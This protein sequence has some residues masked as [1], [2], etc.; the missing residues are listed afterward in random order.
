MYT[1]KSTLGLLDQVGATWKNYATNTTPLSE[2]YRTFSS[3]YLTVHDSYIDK[4]VFV[5]MGVYKLMLTSS[6]QTVDE[7][8]NES[9]NI[10]LATVDALPTAGL[11]S[12]FYEN[13]VLRGYKMQLTKI[14]MTIPENYPT[15]ALDDLQIS[16]PGLPTDMR[17]LHTHCLLSV[18]GYYHTSDADDDYAYII[19]GGVTATSKRCAHT[20]IL[21]FMDIGS[22]TMHRFKDE[23]LVPLTENTPLKDGM[24]IRTDQDLT[25]KSVFMVLGGYIVRPS[26]EEFWQNGDKSFVFY[27][28][29]IPYV[30]RY[31]ESRKDID[32]SSMPVIVEDNDGDQGRLGDNV[33]QESLWS[34]ECLRAYFKISQSFLVIVDTDTLFFSNIPIRVSNIS[35][36]LTS[37]T[38]PQFPLVMGYGKSVE[39]SKVKETSWWALRVTDA[40]YKQ[41]NID[42]SIAPTVKTVNDNILPYKRQLRTTG[43]MLN[44]QGKPKPK[45]VP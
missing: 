28:Q 37:Y 41:Y 45:P 8:L 19:D 6:D 26:K 20:G 29:A 4:D 30:Q 14:G 13:A 1:Y 42:V 38:E 7:W 16:R 23:L 39:Y 43:Y 36:F 40:Y 35:G 33:N 9:K 21:S 17:L 12:A 18:N 15:G 31:L 34:D 11:K 27:P 5:N 3:F 24:I 44:I 25:G 2:L 22:L 10:P 32:L